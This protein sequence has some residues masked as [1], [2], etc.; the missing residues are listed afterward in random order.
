MLLEDSH[1]SFHDK[2]EQLNQFSNEYM[3]MQNFIDTQLNS[4]LQSISASLTNF[5][6]ADGAP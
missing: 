6:N 2:Q 5:T 3:R 4:S 1:Q